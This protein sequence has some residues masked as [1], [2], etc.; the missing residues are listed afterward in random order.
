MESSSHIVNDLPTLIRSHSWEAAAQRLKLIPSDASLDM[1]VLTRGG[2]KANTGFTPLHYACERCPPKEF[3]EILLER[4]PEAVTKRTMPG[5]ALPLHIACTWNA[6]K[7][8]IGTTIPSFS[9][10]RACFYSRLY[11]E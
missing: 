4:Y 11:G 3:V 10:S 9:F 5:G 6:P 1:K 2:F 7:E 8:S